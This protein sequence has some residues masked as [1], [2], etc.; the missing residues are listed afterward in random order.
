MVFQ[1]YSLFPWKTVR[2][3]VEFGLKMKR[4]RA[5]PARVAP[6]A[7]CSAW[8]A[9]SAFEKHYPDQLSGGMK[10]RVGIVRALATGPESAAAR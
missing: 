4:H 5:H 8:P 9:C 3:N 7:R 6:R 2:E 10:Q 1:Q